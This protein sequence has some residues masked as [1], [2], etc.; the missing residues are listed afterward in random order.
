MINKTILRAVAEICTCA[1]YK[2]IFFITVSL[3]VGALIYLLFRP[4]LSWV[5][6]IWGWDKAIID[7]SWL[8]SFVSGFILFHL[9]DILWA[10]A[11]AETIYVI[12]RSL[13]LAVSISFI[14]TTTF[15]TLQFVG[16]VRG[17]GDI[18]DVILVTISLSMYFFIKKG[19]MKMKRLHSTVLVLIAICLF[20]I[21]AI[22]STDNNDTPAR[23]TGGSTQQ[24][25]PDDSQPEATSETSEETSEATNEV[26]GLN[27]TAVFR[28]ISVT[29]EELIIND[30]W[31]S[32]SFT[33][34]TP[35][36]GNK[37][38]AVQFTIENTSDVDQH[39]ST[40]LLFEAYADG[41]KLETSFGAASGLPGT[42]DGN[43]S[44]GRRMVGYYGVEVSQD[45]Q[46]L[47]IEVRSSWLGSGRATFVF[48][49]P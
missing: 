22:A 9:S 31:E 40:L 2:S 24:E 47:E 33:L 38:V 29:A 7:I 20:G 8:P 36:D 23:D 19:Y 15:E 5:P 3:F 17:T 1:K 4:P 14:S 45:A 27:E 25:E 32:E 30:A 48:D 11:F 16:I 43:I 10:L 28:N 13:Y 6:N 12:K 21:I 42:L 35:S 34:F 18:W 26:F 49:I 39:I 41:V 44:P 46:E 37:F